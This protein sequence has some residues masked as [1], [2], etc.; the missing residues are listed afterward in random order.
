MTSYHNHYLHVDLSSGTWSTFALPEDVLERYVGGKGV[1][2]YLLAL[3]QD[4]RAEPFDP[5]NPLIFVTGPLTGTQAPSMR[6]AAIF[7]SPLTCLFT[8][9]YF[10]GFFG[11]ELKYAG[12][13]GLL[14]TGQAARPCY[15]EINDGRVAIQDAAH[16]WGLD[17]YQT[18]ERLR[19]DYPER[20]WR[21]VCIGPAG[22]RQVKFA[23]IDCDPHRQAGRGGGGAVMGAKNLKAIV[24]RGTGK[25]SLADPQGFKERVRA[26]LHEMKD[27]SYIK[28]FHSGGTPASIPW[29]D[30]E[31]LLPTRNFQRGSFPQAEQLGDA[32]QRERYWYR[33][34]A[35][36]ACPIACSKLG[37]LQEGRFAGL[38]GDTLEYESAAMLGSNLEVGQT[39]G[40]IYLGLL[41]DKLGLDTISAGAVLSFA[42]EAVE[43]GLL[44]ADVRFGDVES[45]AA[46]L[47][48]IAARRGVGDLLAEGVRATAAEIGGGADYFAMH[49]K[50]LEL[51]AWGPR[52]V[53]AMGLAY[54]T[55]DRGG[56]H[57]RAF[58]IL[59]EA[60]GET[61]KGQSYER[62]SL[63]G[64]A[65][66]LAEVQNRLAGLDTLI[67]CDFGRYG[68]S[69]QTYLDLLAV[70]TGRRLSLDELYRLGER[71]WNLTRLFNL[72]AGLT[73]EEEDLP[74]RFKEEP[75]P[76]GPA[77]GHRFTEADIERLRADYYAVRGWDENGVP[78]PETLA[79]LEIKYP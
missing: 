4:P 70:A 67:T 28:G 34:I 58:P 66:L 47:Q 17:T 31:G 37:R 59:Y 51:P 43:K 10:G 55:A 16:L 54:M 74:R 46:L 48:D 40:A 24:V 63:E 76:D 30:A 2:A 53:P 52:G 20:E 3:H 22:E 29:A 68:L 65:Q 50:G 35:C 8:D 9:S 26:A 77:A 72:Q 79:A 36:A 13:D 61:W 69:D 39:D 38:E 11:Q 60:G 18:Y 78:K 32:A 57:Q 73:R 42:C 44:K 14:I 19:A 62:L 75:L 41:C 25:L 7:Q 45:L 23:V 5:A 56:C 49:V 21:L 71:I 12:Y 33:D 27:N 6:S 64:K 1:G 15:L